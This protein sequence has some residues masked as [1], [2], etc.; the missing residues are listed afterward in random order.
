MKLLP[1]KCNQCKKIV[2]RNQGRVNEGKKFGWN[3]YCSLK[4]ISKAKNKQQLFTCENPQCSKPFK[5]LLSATHKSRKLYCSQSC[6]AS[7]NNKMYPKRY[8]VRKKCEYCNKEFISRE[9]Y[10]SRPCANK[11]QTISK[12]VIL[13]EIKKFYLIN[14]RIPLKRE[15]SHTKSARVRFGSWNKA[16]KV[17]GFKPNPVMFA[18]K[19]TAV[20]GHICDSLAEKI[21]DDWF[22]KRNI[23]HKRSIP[24]PS[25]LGLHVD[26][27]VGDYWIE[28]FGLHGQ[29][30]RYDELRKEKLK[31]IK[32]YDLKFIEIYPKDLFPT[33]KLDQVLNTLGPVR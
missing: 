20:D 1:I 31:L 23:P 12:E 4:C 3:I 22:Y 2:Y 10:C 33:N 28:F 5:R 8:A 19:H 21:I 32:E 17:A 16:I 18:R 15:F 13:E 6:A 24:Y 30:K 26:F 29:H 7:V 27:R 9:K 14:Q 25:S 11:G